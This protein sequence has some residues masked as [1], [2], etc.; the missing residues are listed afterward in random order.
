MRIVI[1]SLSKKNKM[2]L[3]SNYST[4]FFKRSRFNFKISLTAEKYFTKVNCETW[5][6]TLIV[7]NLRTSRDELASKFVLDFL[8]N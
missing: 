4:L 3:F 7:E 5:D 6:S 2:L 1:Y 8:C